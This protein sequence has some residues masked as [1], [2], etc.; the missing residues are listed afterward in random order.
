M[1]SI[2]V[3]ALVAVLAFSLCGCRMGKNKETTPATE[4]TEPMTEPMTEPRPTQTEPLVDPTIMDPTI[5][6]NVPDP[7]VDDNHLV[8]PTGDGT[9]GDTT[10]DI[11]GRFRNYP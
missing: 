7:S 1:K 2:I 10:P 11:Q 3:I 5:E 8:D 4:A 9:V 6:P